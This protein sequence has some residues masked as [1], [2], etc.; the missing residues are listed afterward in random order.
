M[1]M[2]NNKK[3][4][5][6]GATGSL[7]LE[8][9][10]LL[11]QNGTPVRALIR[12]RDEEEKVKPYTDD[13]WIGD[14]SKGEAEIQNLTEGISTIISALGKSVSLFSPSEDSFYET[15]F[16][17]NK[18]ILEDAV[19]NGVK[20]FIYVSIKGADVEK[21]YS[22][23]K[24]HKMVENELRASG[25]EY[26][27]LRPVGFFS[28]LND[29]A[30]LAKRKLI[31]VIGDGKARTNSIHHRDLAKVVVTYH[32]TGP[33]IIE[34]GGPLIHTRMEMAE[35][36]KDKIGGQIVKIPETMAKIGAAIPKIFDEGMHDKLDYFSFITTNDMIGEQNG[37]ISFK[38]YLSTL[39]LNK[40]P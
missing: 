34:V 19:K 40:L 17:A 33:N 20:R 3:T 1:K 26:T 35:M 22:I 7:G 14:A 24:A 10:K 18:A 27:I 21:D 13:I 5:V 38:E 37:S 25:L 12:S 16:I 39:D 4:L 8:I 31:P 23:A 32:E 2:E 29:L 30:I 36:I 9:L 28:G 6:A 15:D 11:T